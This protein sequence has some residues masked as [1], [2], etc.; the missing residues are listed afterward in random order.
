[1]R[2]S[3]EMHSFRFEGTVVDIQEQGPRL[4][5]GTGVSFRCVILTAP[6]GR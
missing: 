3:L 2:S 1:M 5:T 6:C 4:M